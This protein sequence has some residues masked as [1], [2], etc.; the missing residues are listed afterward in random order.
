MFENIG[1]GEM[2]VILLLIL[3]FFGPKKFPEIGKSIGRGIR[4]FRNAMRDVQEE[5]KIPDLK[6]DIEQT[7][8][9]L[10]EG[11]GL[12]GIKSDLEKTHRDLMG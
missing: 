5:L 8:S 4:E 6:S 10:R 3:I 9:K 12:N 1:G 7:K 2:L 11:M